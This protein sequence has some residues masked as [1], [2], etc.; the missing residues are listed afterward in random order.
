[1][2]SPPRCG[3]AKYLAQQ[4]D[5]ESSSSQSTD[6]SHHDVVAVGGYS[7]HGQRISAQSG[8]FESYGK[9]AEAH[10]KP[11]VS[12]GNPDFVFPA[13]QVDF[14]QTLAPI[15]YS[16]PDPYV[17]GLL[18]AYG[19]QVIIHP[20]MVGIAPARVPLPHDLTEDEPIYVNAKQYRGIL[21]RRQS[22][23]K[24]EAQNKLIKDRKPYL[25]ESRHLHALKRARGSGGRFLNTKKLQQSNPRAATD[26]KDASDSGHLHLGGNLS[27]SEVVQSEN[28][29]G[30]AS[31]T[32][33]SDA[34]SVSNGDEIYHQSDNRFLVY[35]PHMGQTIQGGGGMMCNGSQHRVPVMH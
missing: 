32:S 35:P 27:E 12:L 16:Y 6:Q 9:R 1:M 2:G 28:G 21:R 31:S 24:L 30:G 22:R 20:Q 23:A 7:L 3:N 4:Q 26:G 15:P 5:Q 18:A 11:V 8:I 17:G 33:C 10:M 25:H 29:N 14:S 13:S 19:P 34:T